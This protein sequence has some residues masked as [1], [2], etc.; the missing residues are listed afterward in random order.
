MLEKIKK[1]ISII[2]QVMFDLSAGALTVL[3]V[4]AVIMRYVVSKPIM[5]AEEVQM[6]LIVWCVFFG[7]AIAFSERGHIAVDVFYEMF[8]DKV[9]K[10]V[11]VLIWI[12]TALAV[13]WLGNLLLQ[14]AVTMLG[15]HSVTT[16]LHIPRGFVYAVVA[17]SCLL[18]L[19]SH[20][21]NGIDDLLASRK[22]GVKNE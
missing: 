9:K 21:L 10:A 19:I 6:I 15:N 14:R 16:L 1:V 5:W 17:F 18:M 20:V 3:T 12:I 4:I 11:S 13:G 8:S 22:G 2:N 7:G